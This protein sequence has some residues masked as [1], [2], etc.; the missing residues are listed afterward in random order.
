MARD[1]LCRF[2]LS[3]TLVAKTP[4]HVGGHGDD[5]DTDLPLARN[6]RGELY[7]P[8]TSIAGA[9]RQWCEQA[10]REYPA[11]AEP[12]KDDP[13]FVNRH[14][15][16]QDGAKGQASFVIV[17]DVPV[18]EASAAVVEVR[19][20]VGIDRRRGAA[21]ENIKYDR[22]ILP[23]GTKMKFAL[24]AEAKDSEQRL[25][26]LAMLTALK[27]ALEDARVRLGASKTRGLGRIKLEDG[28]LVEERFSDRQGILAFLKNGGTAAIPGIGEALQKYPARAMRR[29]RVVIHWQPIGPL[30]VKAGFDGIA[31]DMLPLLSGRDGGLSLVLPGSFLKGAMRAR[32][33]RIVRTLLGRDLTGSFLTDLELPLIDDL[34]GLRGLSDGDM[35]RRRREFEKRPRGRTVPDDGALGLAALSVDDCY[36]KTSL[37]RERWAAVQGTT[38]D[39]ALRNALGAAGLQPWSQAYHVAVDR[40]TG[41]TA[42]SMLYTVLEPHRAEWEPLELEVNLR[43]LRDAEELPAVALLLVVLR[44]LAQGRLPLGFA[45]HRGMGAVEVKSVTI[46]PQSADAPLDGLGSVTVSNHGLANV[47]PALN[48]AWRRWIEREAP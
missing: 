30:M 28:K 10:F 11:F 25:A 6:G 48:Q 43:R 27:E 13:G 46:T 18:N 9:L 7:V 4:L 14:W 12:R 34:F 32:A 33:E 39:A 15:G 45:T 22:A 23:R 1:L 38:T 20:G 24:S 35:Q 26:V 17:E 8:G 5:V 41:A 21:A 19:D 36:G 3:G 2:R 16:F 40:W 29:L 42:E 31:V 44:D 37:S 47:P